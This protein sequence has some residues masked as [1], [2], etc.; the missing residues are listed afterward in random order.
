M[1]RRCLPQLFL[2]HTFSPKLETYHRKRFIRNEKGFPAPTSDHNE[3][4]NYRNNGRVTHRYSDKREAEVEWKKLL[5][6]APDHN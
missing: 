5:V 6:L 3:S 2:H 4:S 1:E